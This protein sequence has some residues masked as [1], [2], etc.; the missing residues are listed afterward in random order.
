MWLPWLIRLQNATV[1][2]GSEVALSANHMLLLPDNL[3]ATG[4][5][6]DT[7]HLIQPYC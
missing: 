5:P 4:H 6:E 3:V 1:L 2:S 7:A